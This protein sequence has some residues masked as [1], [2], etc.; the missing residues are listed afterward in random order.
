MQIIRIKED[1]MKKYLLIMLIVI[2]IISLV[3]CNEKDI[4]DSKQK[5]KIAVSIN[6]FS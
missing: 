3:G 1:I 6:I 4:D 5:V 2:L